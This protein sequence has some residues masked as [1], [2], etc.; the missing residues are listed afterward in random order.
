MAEIIVLVCTIIGYNFLFSHVF[1]AFFLSFRGSGSER[2]GLWVRVCLGVIGFILRIVWVLCGLWWFSG[3]IRSDWGGFKFQAEMSGTLH[4]RFLVRFG[5][6]M[7]FLSWIKVR[8]GS[9]VPGR[10]LYIF[11]C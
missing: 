11:V 2:E 1:L 10:Y 4:I 8:L 5:L 3:L 7:F 6:W 9:R